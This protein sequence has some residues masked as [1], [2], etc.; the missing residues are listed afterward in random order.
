VD[1]PSEPQWF[2][3]DIFQRIVQIAYWLIPGT[4]IVA[5]VLVLVWAYYA[6]S[7]YTTVLA[8]IVFSGLWLLGRYLIVLSVWW[9]QVLNAKHA[10]EVS[11]MLKNDPK[12]IPPELKS[13]VVYDRT[14]RKLTG[15]DLYGIIDNVQ[16]T[17]IKEALLPLMTPEDRPA[18]EE[19]M[20]RAERF[21]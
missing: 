6:E 15:F 7:L 11:V 20:R 18:V 9:R 12:P 1:Q 4:V 2:C 5:D 8:A 10:V 13:K 3:P 17:R 16:Q 14:C 21:W 19:L